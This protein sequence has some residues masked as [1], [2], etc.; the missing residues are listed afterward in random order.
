M[1][2]ELLSVRGG[3]HLGSEGTRL[4]ETH[5]RSDDERGGASSALF[6]READLPMVVVSI[7][8]GMMDSRL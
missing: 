8:Q 2:C 1:W 7:D 3:K 5:W 6:D 4:R